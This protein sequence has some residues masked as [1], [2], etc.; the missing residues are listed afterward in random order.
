MV[1]VALLSLAAS[2]LRGVVTKSLGRRPD[3]TD[4]TEIW[5]EVLDLK[6][7]PFIGVGFASFW[8]TPNG[9]DLASD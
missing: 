9:F 4:R 1:L 5:K 2:E 6:T 8:L 7:D 3:L